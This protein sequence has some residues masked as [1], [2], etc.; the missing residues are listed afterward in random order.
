MRRYIIISVVIAVAFACLITPRISAADDDASEAADEAIEQIEEMCHDLDWRNRFS[1]KYIGEFDF[2]FGNYLGDYSQNTWTTGGR[3]YFHINHIFAV[4]AEYMYTDLRVDGPSSFGQVKKTDDQ[5]I[6]DGQ[7][8]INNEILFAAGKSQIPM[9][10]YLTVGG[11]M[12]NTNRSWNWLAMIGGG[13]KVYLK[14]KWMAL[15]VDV[16]SYIHPNPTIGGDEI[17][18]DVS[19]LFGL[20]FHF[21]YRVQE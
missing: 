15:R 21:P 17:A 5:H 18:G 8:M 2:F 11:G 10:L 1:K 6:I 16:N 9:D 13:L 14:P 7:L 19:F 3:A 20:A 12:I 4:G